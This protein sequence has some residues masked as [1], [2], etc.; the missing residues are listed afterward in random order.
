MIDRIQHIE[1][2]FPRGT[3]TRQ[4]LDF[5]GVG[6][7]DFFSFFFKCCCLFVLFQLTGILK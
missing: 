6:G 3:V 4:G 1:F 7:G 2:T 5:S